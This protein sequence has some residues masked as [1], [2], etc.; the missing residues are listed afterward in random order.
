MRKEFIIRGQLDGTSGKGIKK[1]RIKG[2]PR[3]YA[4]RIT[5]FKLYP[6]A[7]I[8][9]GA[10]ESCA[11]IARGG[12]PLD[13]ISPN[14]D[15]QALVA[16]AKYSIPTGPEHGVMTYSVIN[17]LANITQDLWIYAIDTGGGNKPINFQI[18]FKSVK[19]TDAA[20]A[21]ANYEA[22]ALSD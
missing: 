12:I 18:K 8:G 5:D 14:F 2:K 16:V 13:P 4:V 20:E 3:G 11:S 17:D 19:M 10:T 21:T 1:I 22:F 6:G 15:N 7:D 9:S